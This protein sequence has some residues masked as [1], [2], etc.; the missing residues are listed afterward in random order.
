MLKIY[1]FY[2]FLF[3]GTGKSKL[4]NDISDTVDYILRHNTETHPEKPIVLKT[5]FT[6]IAASNI[7]GNTL[8]KP[9]GI[10]FT[11]HFVSMN[12]GTKAKLQDMLEDLRLLIID[13]IS[14]VRP[15]MLYQ[16]NL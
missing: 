15:D 3:L 7:G 5:A 16:V 13:E 9:F 14:M 11:S 2:I 4:I 1:I 10:D 12:D 6:G 8:N